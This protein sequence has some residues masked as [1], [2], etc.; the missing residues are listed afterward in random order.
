MQTAFEVHLHELTEQVG[1]VGGIGPEIVIEVGRRAGLPG[2]VEGLEQG[3]E[4]GAVIEERAAG[5]VAGHSEALARP[6][7][8]QRLLPV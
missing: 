3:L 2:V 8:G 6:D 7:C 5:R 1:V 4:L